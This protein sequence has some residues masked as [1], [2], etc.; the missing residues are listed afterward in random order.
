MDHCS[1]ILCSKSTHNVF[2]RGGQ[3]RNAFTEYFCTV[4]DEQLLLQIVIAACNDDAKVESEHVRCSQYLC[5]T[6]YRRAADVAGAQSRIVSWRSRWR[7][8]K[9]LTNGCQQ[10]SFF[11]SNPRAIIK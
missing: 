3:I 9:S 10:L 8:L 4:T 1:Q 6:A 2:L 11:E 7:P 5:G